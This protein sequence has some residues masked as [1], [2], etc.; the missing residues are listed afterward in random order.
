MT[1]GFH[2]I[3]LSAALC[4]GSFFFLAS[5]EN[6]IKEV[7]NLGKGK[8]NIEEGR[9][10][11]SFLSI[12]GMVK[13]RLKAPYMIRRDKDSA[14]TI[15]P[16]SLFVTFYNELVP[17]PESFLKAKY[18]KYF[19]DESKVFLRDSVVFYNIKGDT[20]RTSELWWDQKTEE[21]YTD[22]PIWFFQKV[23]FS[24]I[25][26][27]GFRTKQD[28]SSYHFDQVYDSQTSVADSTLP[29]Q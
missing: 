28:F 6:D 17:I 14:A 12:G 5:C 24:L 16:N 20:M 21:L 26:G 27:R 18:G 9:D 4:I 3:F 2:H 10:I 13:A 1:K 8:E 23:P 19:V 11:E 29:S 15:F 7:Q 22:K 25:K